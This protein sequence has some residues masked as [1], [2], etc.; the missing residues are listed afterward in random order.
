[1]IF[2]SILIIVLIAALPFLLY[3]LCS[4]T[5]RW[6][7]RKFLLSRNYGKWLGWAIVAVLL[8]LILYGT[9]WGFEKIVVRHEQYVSSQLPK[10]FDGYRIVHISDLH[11]GTYSRS[12]HSVVKNIV[13]SINSLDADLVVFTGD[14]QNLVPSEIDEHTG[15]LKNK[16]RA[17]DGVI[18]VLGNHDYAMYIDADEQTKASNLRRTIAAERNLGWTL[19]LNDHKVMRRGA[20][21]IV[22][23]GME[24]D[25]DGK[26]FPQR[27]NVRETLSD[28]DSAAFVVMLEHDPS[29][30]R[31]KILPYSQA[32]LTLSGHTHAMQFM[33]GSWSPVSFLY[34]E[35]GGMYYEDG[36]AINVST[37]AGGFIP[38]RLGV[39]N[40]VVVITLRKT[41]NP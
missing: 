35:W 20:D 18:S 8:L 12:H 27:G 15:E 9:T 24:N 33:I 32:Q 22:I 40:E 10:A 38:F 3:K 25:G 28:V 21:S 5:G 23:A 16:I 1:M 6:A 14:L 31:R 29:S 36:R 34:S 26:R 4:R 13:D 19:L 2:R 37:G 39:P 11:L 30:W 41:S 7:K 17:K